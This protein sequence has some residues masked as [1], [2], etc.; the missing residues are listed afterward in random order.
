MIAATLCGCTGIAGGMVLGPLFLAYNMVP[1]V[2][3]GTNQYITM[4]A[5][6]ATCI[7]FIYIGELLWG[8]ALMFGLITLVAA[9]SG[10]KAIN[11]YI[12]KSGKQSTITVILVLV[13][14]L[15]LIALPID[16]LLKEYGYK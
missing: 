2:M 15:A 13:L 6:I 8:H 16:Y 9:Y 1:Q 4:I 14:S 10:L 5:S 11:V 12:A 3:S 7:Q